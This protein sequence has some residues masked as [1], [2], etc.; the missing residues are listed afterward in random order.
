MDMKS[1]NEAAGPAKCE[2][3]TT[4]MLHRL[5]YGEEPGRGF[6]PESLREHLP[7]CDACLATWSSIAKRDESLRREFDR[8][9]ER[10]DHI[11][12]AAR[13]GRE[14]ANADYKKFRAEADRL[15]AQIDASEGASAVEERDAAAAAVFTDLHLAKSQTLLRGPQLQ[16]DGA[17][18]V[19]VIVELISQILAIPDSTQRFTRLEYLAQSCRHALRFMPADIDRLMSKTQLGNPKVQVYSLADPG[20]LELALTVASNPQILKRS[21]KPILDVTKDS[22]VFNG[23]AYAAAGVSASL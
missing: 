4:G 19:R 20:T 17:E 1:E 8:F 22:L 21:D 18:A 3:V 2:A 15:R 10:M 23:V 16:A 6:T 14:E 11:A 7:G 5:Y 13:S 9:R 12:S